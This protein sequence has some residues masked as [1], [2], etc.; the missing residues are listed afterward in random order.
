MGIYE[1]STGRFV[2][3]I[4]LDLVVA[5]RYGFAPLLD[6]G[7]NVGYWNLSER[8]LS[9]EGSAWLV[10]QQPLRFFHFSG[11]DAKR[12][13]GRRRFTPSEAHLAIAEEYQDRLRTADLEKLQ[14]LPDLR[15][16]A[17]DSRSR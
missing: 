7:L 6:P 10:N 16:I 2:D 13:T 15:P 1:P 5:E 12:L 14:G 17:T 11:F 9:R 3:Q 4:W 8:A